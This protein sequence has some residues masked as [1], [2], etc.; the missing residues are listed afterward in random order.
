[1]ALTKDQYY[2]YLENLDIN[3]SFARLHKERGD[4]QT[5]RY[6]KLTFTFTKRSDQ[7]TYITQDFEKTVIDSVTNEARIERVENVL[8]EVVEP[9]ETPAVELTYE[10]ARIEIFD[11]L[12]VWQDT[13]DTLPPI[14]P[15]SEL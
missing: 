1:M 10:Q 2:L 15:P 13:L 8:K 14:T 7:A 6:D 11:E 4:Q 5:T 12:A 3:P 9:P